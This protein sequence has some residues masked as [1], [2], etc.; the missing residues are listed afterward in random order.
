MSCTIWF[1]CTQ[2]SI[3]V[4]TQI[5]SRQLP[6]PSRCCWPTPQKYFRY[7]TPTGLGWILAHMIIRD[8]SIVVTS[9]GRQLISHANIPLLL[10]TQ[11]PKLGTLPSICGIQRVNSFLKQCLDVRFS[12]CGFVPL[13]DCLGWHRLRSTQRGSFLTSI[14]D[15]T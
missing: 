12:G 2:N 10:S 1:Q 11:H 3:L 15:N 4:H 8:K 6:A 14:L 5:L 13:W 7:P 9:L